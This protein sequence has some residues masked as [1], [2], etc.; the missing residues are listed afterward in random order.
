MLRQI[1][2]R[3]WAVTGSRLSGQNSAEHFIEGGGAQARLIGAGLSR[4]C[5]VEHG[6]AVNRGVGDG[7]AARLGP[8]PHGGVGS[9]GPGQV[10]RVGVVDAD[11]GNPGSASRN[12]GESGD[13]LLRGEESPA[14]TEP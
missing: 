12:C 11:V 4:S 1:L 6:G 8:A 7:V 2:G 13:Q 14:L 9:A 10:R 3:E 5:G